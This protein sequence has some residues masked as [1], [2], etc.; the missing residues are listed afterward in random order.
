MSQLHFQT[1]GLSVSY[2]GL[3]IALLPKEYALLDFLYQNRGHAF[4]REELLDRVW[5]LETPVDR[6]VDDHVYR[7]RKK[8]KPCAEV[9]SLDT[10]R[11]IGYRLTVKDVRPLTMMPSQT[12]AELNEYAQKMLSKYHLFGQG[13]A[14]M[15]MYQ[16]QKVL[17]IEIDPFYEVY[18]RFISGD[19]FWLVESEHVPIEHRLY[20][21]L[22]LF[23]VAQ[24]DTQEALDFIERALATDLLPEKNRTELYILDMLFA[25]MM[26]G[27][28]DEVLERFTTVT[29]PL[30]EEKGWQEG[31]L[32]PTMLAE[33]AA[34]FLAGQY[35][36]MEGNLNRVEKM[37][38]EA[39][40][41][42]ETG[43]YRLA[44]GVWEIHNGRKAA[45]KA[46]LEE[47]LDI[48]RQSKFVPQYLFHL[49]K[50]VYF[51]EVQL[52]EPELCR[53]YQ[54][55]WKDACKQYRLEEVAVKIREVLQ[56]VL[57]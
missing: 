9:V 25:M 28:V 41:L 34:F 5:P 10:V 11:S 35:E 4:T 3:T 15:M 50:V 19:F 8:L 21:L 14:L 43:F 20:L 44:R 29:Y 13:D 12:D 32:M 7:L 2:K 17:G 24:D 57:L 42:R 47:G 26:T 27:R 54:G 39:P 52:D 33:S 37:I 18:I 49:R 36:K 1:D 40:Y 23:A 30:I 55:L 51:F 22:V 45:G 31:F 6:T 38:Q 56:N 46:T 53:E 16:Q 48:L